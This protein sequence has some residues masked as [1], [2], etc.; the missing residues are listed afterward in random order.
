MSAI[1]STFWPIGCRARTCVAGCW[2]TMRT[3]F[4]VSRPGAG[5]HRGRYTREERTRMAKPKEEQLIPA[6]GVKET[7]ETDNV[8]RWDGDHLYVEH[9]VYHNGQLVHRKY[10]RKVTADVARALLGVLAAKL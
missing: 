2:S 6:L 4:T 10:H 9:D 8:L 3:G 5:D 7:T 1:C